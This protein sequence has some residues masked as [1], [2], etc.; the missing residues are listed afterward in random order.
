MIYYSGL[1]YIFR[2]RPIAVFTAR[3]RSIGD[4]PKSSDRQLNAAFRIQSGVTEWLIYVL[5]NRQIYN[6]SVCKRKQ[7]VWASLNRCLSC[8]N[9]CENTWSL[10]GSTLSNTI[11]TRHTYITILENYQDQIVVEINR[12]YVLLFIFKMQRIFSLCLQWFC[13]AHISSNKPFSTKRIKW[14]IKNLMR[15]SIPLSVSHFS[16]FMDTCF[17][18][19]SPCWAYTCLIV[20]LWD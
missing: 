2:S 11:W 7:L 16:Y 6:L 1:R 8:W 5:V 19:K 15:N 10:Q 4:N 3:G 20:S 14:E 9:K 17:T 12:I 13:V 18:Y